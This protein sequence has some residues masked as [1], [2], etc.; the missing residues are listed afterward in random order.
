MTMKKINTIFIFILMATT[1][2]PENTLA[3][4]NDENYT[5]TVPISSGRQQ[6]I[7]GQL[8]REGADLQA[9][10]IDMVLIPGGRFQMGGPSSEKGR[11]DDERQH[12]IYINDFKMNRTEVTLKAF[13]QFVSATGYR[14]DAQKNTGSKKGCYSI[15]D[16]KWSYVAGRNYKNPGFKQSNNHPVVCVSYNDAMAYINWLNNMTGVRFRLPTEAEWEYAARGDTDSS[17]F[18]GNKVDSKAY[19]YT[20]AYGLKEMSDS[21][22]EWTCSDGQSTYSGQENSGQENVVQ[23]KTCSSSANVFSLYSRSWKYRSTWVRSVL[24]YQFNAF[25]RY[26]ILSFR[27]VQVD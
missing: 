17:R 10:G 19:R 23:E 20:N 27:L 26:D 3:S 8:V 15:K 21:I 16:N 6:T 4:S 12:S 2:I 13:K 11:D 9:Y 14:T 1:F 25:L 22:W 5:E 24:H 7:Q 18:W